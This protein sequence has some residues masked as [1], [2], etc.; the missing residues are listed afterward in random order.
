MRSKIIGVLGAVVV[1][2][3]ACQTGT[4]LVS[5]SSTAATTSSHDSVR[6][7]SQVTTTHGETP[8]ESFSAGSTPIVPGPTEE[9][10]SLAVPTLGGCRMFPSDSPW[11]QDVSTAPIHPQSA[12]YIDTIGVD[13]TLHA[14]FGSNPEYGIPFIV[15]PAATPQVPIEFVEYGDESDPGPTRFLRMRRW[16]SEA[17]VICW[18]W[19]RG[20]AGSMSCIMH[21]A[22]ATAGR[23]VRARSSIFPA[24][25][26][27]RKAGLRRTPPVCPSCPDWCA[28]TRCNPARSATRC[29]L[30][31]NPP[32]AE[33]RRHCR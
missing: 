32:R 31:W 19:R 33:Y 4:A 6:E 9:I 20:N 22:P 12:A 17:I 2:T 1:L 14:D 28:T 18:C 10:P 8:S 23:W 21:S 16:N 27:A 11:N 3:F 24:T 29:A 7:T 15:A 26:S 13:T 25:R 30:R 5:S